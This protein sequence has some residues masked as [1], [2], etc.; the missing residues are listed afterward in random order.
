VKAEADYIEAID[1]ASSSVE[2]VA[3]VLDRL[4][5]P[6]VL[7]DELALTP[8]AVA[9][10]GKLILVKMSQHLLLVVFLAP[11]VSQ[12]CIHGSPQPERWCLS[13][14]GPEP[15]QYDVLEK[16][17]RGLQARDKSPAEAVRLAVASGNGKSALVAD[18][19]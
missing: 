9:S 14:G 7:A 1:V 15:W 18:G 17:G 13:T 4:L 16:F 8:Q 6:T 3:H 10:I 5:L 12:R 19:A 2:C 11:F